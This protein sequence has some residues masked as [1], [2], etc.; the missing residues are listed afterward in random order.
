MDR[1][2]ED[3]QP[4]PFSFSYVTWNQNSKTGGALRHYDDA[5]LAASAKKE[6]RYT[7][8]ANKKSNHREN[9]TRHIFIGDEKHPR[10]FNI[11][12]IIRFNGKKVVY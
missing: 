6:K 5:E 10:K 11:R 4:V 12:S 2:T 8:N 9:M 1:K 7:S 3:G